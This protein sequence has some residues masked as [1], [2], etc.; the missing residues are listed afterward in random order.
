MLFIC[1]KCNK[2]HSALNVEC[3]YSVTNHQFIY[4]CNEHLSTR[5][6]DMMHQPWASSYTEECKVCDG[7]S[8]KCAGLQQEGII[9][10]GTNKNFCI[11][12]I[13]A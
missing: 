5:T 12:K 7:K 6:D 10:H 8:D 1:K 13:N 9:V 11:S 2:G 4:L 3:F